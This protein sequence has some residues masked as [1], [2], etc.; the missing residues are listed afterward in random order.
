MYTF[1]LYYDN[2]SLKVENDPIGWDETNFVA[3]RSKTDG[4]GTFKNFNLDLVW[5]KDGAEFIRDI[6]ELEG[7]EAHIRAEVYLYNP[8]TYKNDLILS[9]KLNLTEYSANTDRG[10]LEVTAAIEN[11][12]F[13]VTFLSL[14][15]KDVDLISNKDI[16]DNTI[17]VAPIVTSELHSKSISEDYQGKLLNDKLSFQISNTNIGATNPLQPSDVSRN[18]VQEFWIAFSMDDVIKS[19]LQKPFQLGFGHTTDFNSVGNFFQ[20]DFNTKAS[21][22]ANIPQQ[23]DLRFYGDASG[24]R[25]NC[26]DQRD[27]FESFI[28]EFFFEWRDKDDNVKK[29]T[30]I[31]TKSDSLCK[32]GTKSS[33]QIG[34]AVITTDNHTAIMSIGDGSSHFQLE[35]TEFLAGDKLYFYT[36]VRHEGNYHRLVFNPYNI[37][38][39]Y[40]LSVPKHDSTLISLSGVSVFGETVTEGIMVHEAFDQVVKHITG[41][42]GRF[43]SDYFGRIDL[44]Y[45]ADGPG[46]FRLLAKGKNLRGVAIAESIFMSFDLLMQ[47]ESLDAISFGF[48][49][50]ND[51]TIIRVEPIEYFYPTDISLTLERVAKL[52]KKVLAEKYITTIDFGYQKWTGQKDIGTLFEINSERQYHTGLTQIDNNQSS[53]SKLVT[54]SYSIES[55]RRLSIDLNTKDGQYDDDVFVIQVIKNTDPAQPDYKSESDENLIS[56]SGVEDAEGLYNIRLT[57][58]RSLLR[59]GRVLASSFYKNNKVQGKIKFASGKGNYLAVSRLDGEQEVAE[60]GD[61]DMEQ[62][63]PIWINEEYSFEYPLT[64][65]EFNTLMQQTKKTIKFTDNSNKAFYGFITEVEIDTRTP[66]KSLSTFKLLRAR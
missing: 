3:K 50:E 14:R 24:R 34:N 41:K 37:T 65:E 48:E 51:Q 60:N 15:K 22:L 31:G 66:G 23:L 4:H 61:F 17:S 12:E 5:I 7:I 46:A 45:A 38:Q 9:G 59:W 52:N 49:T 32:K 6:Y 62:F 28:Y 44:G 55:M 58:A 29:R 43:K 19:S 21:V 63:T 64:L 30:L 53:L 47:Q 11:E 8:N 33:D 13:Q 57:P 1:K 27:M 56:I 36:H 25:V 39:E 18:V 40:T 54:G 16:K 42:T 2:Q 35:E 20:F 10:R 26:G